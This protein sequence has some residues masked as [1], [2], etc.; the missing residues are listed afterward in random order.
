LDDAVARGAPYQA[1]NL[2]GHVRR[3]F[4]WAIARGAYGLERSPCDRMKPADVI[5]RKALRTRIL[6]DD[7]LR[8]LW[9]ATG[10]MG[11]PFGPL[12]RLL[13]VTGQRKSEVA[14]ASWP[15]F[16]FE[17]KLWTIPA[18]RMKSDAP[19]AVP[20]TAEAIAILES[21]P[22]FEHLD[23][24]FSTTFG[25]KPVSG[26]SKAKRRLDGLMLAELKKAAA[27]RGDSPERTKLSEFVLH[28]IR[29]SVR[30]GLSALPVPDLVRE[31]V[32]AHTKPGLHKVYDQYAWLSEKRE[33]LELWA[34]RLRAIVE[35]PPENVVPLQ[36]AG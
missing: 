24:L 8:A 20:L 2:L 21:L 1:H 6:S 28:D 4:N 32:I 10:T 7:E 26:F 35:P 5:G 17:R 33:A 15:E 9:V 27:E 31:L 16:D 18:E 22:R 34:A 36:R 29:R 12:L 13:A 3:L 23:F 14:E 30:T 25:T 11:Y 19:H